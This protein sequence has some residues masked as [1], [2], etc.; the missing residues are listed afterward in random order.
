[1]SEGQKN[2]GNT[3]LLLIDIQKG[4]DEEAHWGKRNN[5][6]A[7]ANAARLLALFRELELPVFHI[8]HLS[9]EENSP[10]RPEK[11][12]AQIK[13]LVAP[14]GSEPVITK[15][16]NSAFIGT[17]L[18]QRL[19]ALG[20]SELVL[21]GLTTDHC[22]STSTRMAGNLGFKAFLA[23]DAC[24]TFD[25]LAPDGRRWTAEDIHSSALASLNGEFAEVISSD[26]IISRLRSSATLQ[27][28]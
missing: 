5:P 16:V 23:E 1:M 4:F 18:E 6:G 22:V 21:A 27:K 15:N 20:I 8:Q 24:A 25:R 11:A 7:E 28:S 2:D 26:E 17:D 14:R 13:E 3:A 19:Q 12:G 9:T 10:L